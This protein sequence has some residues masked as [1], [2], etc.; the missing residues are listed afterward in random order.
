VLQRLTDA[1]HQAERVRN[2][3]IFQ[4]VYLAVVAPASP[5]EMTTAGAL[6]SV[7]DPADTNEETALGSAQNLGK[8]VSEKLQS[9]RQAAADESTDI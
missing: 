8:Q 9:R 4:R 5:S 7:K 1:P 3:H 6:R 2:R